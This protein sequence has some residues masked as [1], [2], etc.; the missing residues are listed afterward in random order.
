MMHND[1]FNVEKIN[2]D[3]ERLEIPISCVIELTT[4]CNWKCKHCYLPEHNSFGLTFEEIKKL[5]EDF[6]NI[7]IHKIIYTGGEIFTRRDAVEIIEYTRSQGFLVSVLSNAS[8]ISDEI[9]HR[10]RRCYISGFSMTVFSMNEDVHD[11]ITGVKGS[12]KR[13]L[14]GAQLMKANGN[15]VWIKS[16]V[17]KDNMRDIKGVQNYCKENGFAYT[18]SACIFPRND[19]DITPMSYTMSIDEL[20]EVISFIDSTNNFEERSFSDR[21]M[22]KYLLRSFAVTFDGNVTPC[23]S[24]FVKVGNLREKSIYEIWNNDVYREIRHLKNCQLDKCN[25]CPIS[26]Y[27]DRCPATVVSE[28]GT[29]YGCSNIA[30]NIAIA[31]SNVYR[32]E[33]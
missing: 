4:R 6:R 28:G 23:N 22:C 17:L 24:M 21:L 25:T 1:I 3:A 26:N 12:L 18:S 14:R 29:Y 2:A 27:C 5:L 15:S 8:L 16:P 30:K 32:K 9:A 31:R 33:V 20:T 7:G 11:G 13:A 19:G 10:L